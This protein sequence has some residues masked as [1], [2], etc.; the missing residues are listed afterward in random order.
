MEPQKNY[1]GII[2]AVAAIAILG[3]AGFAFSKL[4]NDDN[5]IT[6]T[7]IDRSVEDTEISDTVNLNDTVKTGSTENTKDTN[8][9]SNKYGDG[10]YEAMGSYSTPGGLE[11]IDITLALKD[12]IIVAATFIGNTENPASIKNQGLFRDGFTKQVV[13][14][15]LATL[16][17]GVVNGSSLTP[18]GFMDAVVKIRA[19]AQS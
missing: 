2:K 3:V 8:A 9:T 1:G 14:K 12:D 5:Q 6:N 7:D 17:L 18:K 15:P 19:Q 4:G 16:N 10:N 11:E 13:G